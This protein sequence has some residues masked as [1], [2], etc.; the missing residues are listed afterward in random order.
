MIRH[1]TAAGS[2]GLSCMAAAVS[3]LF[4]HDD[5]DDDDG[6]SLTVWP[7]PCKCPHFFAACCKQTT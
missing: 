4:A 3:L 1:H 2:P 5:D 6:A 7:V